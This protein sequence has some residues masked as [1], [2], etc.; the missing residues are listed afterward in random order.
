MPSIDINAPTGYIY[1]RTPT[2]YMLF[3]ILY[4]KTHM[5]RI[6][7]LIYNRINTK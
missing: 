4:Y 3:N 7:Q 6:K 5:L 1:R 2:N